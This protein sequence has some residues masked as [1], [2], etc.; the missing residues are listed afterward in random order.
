M[1]H[2][3]N[4]GAAA[5]AIAAVLA[6]PAA[7]QDAADASGAE[8]ST[9][10]A[11]AEQSGRVTVR[12]AD[13]NPRYGDIDA[14]YGDIDAFW[15]DISPFYG[16][17]DAFW[18][19][20][21]PFWDDISPF[22]GDI[23]AFWGD[24]D[25][26]WDDISPFDK[27]KLA[28][29]GNFWA[30]TAT[31]FRETET[32]WSQLAAD[33]DNAVLANDVR[34]KL[35][36]LVATSSA[37]WG[38]SVTAKTGQSFQQGFVDTI[39][40]KHQIDPN[41]PASLA[42]LTARERAAFFV[43]WHDTLMQYAGIDH[44]DHWMGA[45]N[46]TPSI[47]Q[48][49]GSTGRSVIGI[50]DSTVTGSADL[51]DNVISSTGH[52]GFVGGHGA[53]VASLMVGAHDGQGVM[54]IAPN[55]QVIAHNPFD[56]T[57]SA[58]WTDVRDGIVQLTQHGASIV[59]L[60]LGETGKPFS[61]EWRGV[62]N[63]P[64][65]AANA[66]NTVYVL[67][68]GN[69]GVAQTDDIEWGGAFD[70]SFILVG[71]V[72]PDGT[73]SAFSNTPGDACLLNAGV[74]GEGDALMNR[75]I[76]APGEMILVDDGHGGLVRRSGT[77]FSAP[78]VSGAI[79]LLHDRWPWLS[80]H[81]DESVEIILRSAR[82]LG[83]P[84]VDPIYGAGM[85]DVL[86]SQSPLDF[87]DMYYKLFQRSGFYFYGRN[88]SAT[89]LF[90]M[91]VPAWWETNDVFFTLYEDVGD[92]Y[93]D[94]SVP[95]STYTMGKR[96]NAL[97]GG[98]QRL[99]DFVSSRFATWIHSKGA[100]RNGNGRAG[101]SQIRTGGERSAGDWSIRYSAAM[102]R[103]VEDGSMAPVHA[104]ASITDPSNRFSLTMG[105][106]QG[107]MALSGSRFGV[108][109]DFD[110]DE[111]GVNPVLGFASG[112]FFTSASLA[113]SPDTQLRLGYSENRLDWRDIN[114]NDVTQRLY[115]RELGAQNAQAMTVDL[116]QRVS[117]AV[118]L[119]LQYTRLREDDALL[120]AQTDLDL[121]LGDGSHTDALTVSG[122]AHLADNL[123]LD[124]SATA[125]RTSAA[126]G[127]MLSTGDAI[128][129]SAGQ[130]A[131][132]R[133]NLFAEADSFRIAVGQPLTI[134]QGS[135]DLDT[136]QVV[137]R[138]TGETGRVTQSI[139]IETKRR[140]LGELVYATPVLEG[141]GELGFFGRYV[142][143]GSISDDD[144]LML[145][146]NFGVRF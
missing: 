108:I 8:A 31:Q 66:G 110:R 13:L 42:A 132:T 106:G 89:T 65:I 107:A 59:N 36:S 93:R 48:I 142:S 88:V 57:N 138:E 104:A 40:A 19:D 143:E 61:G 58:S 4:F 79:A 26:F 10:D 102:P 123:R 99:Q 74:C 73:I 68:S 101:F 145:G 129:S 39:F 38:A 95:M 109:S 85:L 83:A 112:E 115:Q 86:A 144:G 141:A 21:N 6:A 7:A 69:E 77:S 60:S 117:D 55:A 37:Q 116:E 49:Q 44:V 5:I 111:G 87:N 146:I 131:L 17:I 114:T 81:P 45:I 135:L 92:T 127:Q 71:S 75:F 90:N 62:F 43:D 122:T 15:D 82:D 100:D 11:S 63:D 98:F 9:V 140:M 32:A 130:I 56:A 118:S 35:D 91:G 27:A 70:T 47:T 1:V 78:L 24:I 76:V 28:E 67:A 29:L 137:D 94:F 64:T 97:G 51:A 2:T 53:G 54:G 3:F 50:L 18:D 23:D 136:L 80:Q 22:Y 103:L 72:S 16:D 33:A 46:W 113:F 128:R 119:N 139:G 134:E 125:S 30:T 126:E 12:A 124:M 20:I 14:F 96:T 52:D 121:L 34:T 105:H 84:G 25:A 120:G 41:D 133:S